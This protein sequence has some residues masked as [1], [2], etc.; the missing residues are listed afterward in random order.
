MAARPRGGDAH[1]TPL[2]K[3]FAIAIPG[4]EL[5]EEISRGGQ[6]IVYKGQHRTTGRPVAVKL[7]RDGTLSDAVSRERLQREARVLAALNHPNI[8]TVIDAG[9]SPDGHDYLVMNYIAG[10]SLDAFFDDAPAGRR[11]AKQD[12]ADADPSFL[13]RLFATVCDAV[14]AA[15]LRGITHRD[16]SPSNIRVD[17]ANQPHVLDFGL[18]K[19]AFDRFI[20]G[21]DGGNVSITG[22]FLGKLAYASPEQA[23][24]DAD[25]IDIRTDV[26]AL[27]VIL[28]QVLTG[29][30]FPYEVAGN[31]VEV[32]NN[33]IHAQPT[34]PST[35]ISADVSTRALSDRTLKTAHPPL[36]N[37]A[38]E[39]I[40]MKALAK[41]PADRYQT[42]GEFGRDVR[43]YLAGGPSVM[44]V[45]KP[46]SKP[47]PKPRPK[48][49]PTRSPEPTSTRAR[50]PRGGWLTLWPTSARRAAIVT[51]ATAATC[52]G[53]AALA[54]AFE[55]QRT[56]RDLAALAA[57]RDGR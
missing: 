40:V 12:A 19:T 49:E 6:A 55:Y 43:Q 42:A 48:P 35:R 56:S 57:E 15:H 51:V 10:R 37:E 20:A 46:T 3:A 27:G 39:A 32:L 23:A 53:V 38:I 33:I 7:L 47:L 11:G 36:I 54:Y 30:R 14:N 45:A 17:E 44:V 26:Y 18:A 5:I 1:A 25:H 28:Y 34:P 22:Q 21:R 16:L 50:E 29:G 9:V 4:Y 52:A 8:V 24:G 31:M 13:L 41:D 2:L